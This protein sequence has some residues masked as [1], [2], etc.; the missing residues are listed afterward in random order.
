MA[1]LLRPILLLLF[2]GFLAPAWARV[3]LAVGQAAIA[4]AHPLATE[5]G[6]EILA[7]GGNAFDAAVAVSAA[8]AVVEPYASGVGGGGFWLLHRDSDGFETM[9]DGRETAPGAAF[10]DMYLDKSG[11]PLA[12]ASLTGP[13]AAAVPGMPAGLVRLARYGRLP[14]KTTMAPA[15]RLAE[16]GFTVDE[17][18]LRA[19][20]ETA[21]RLERFPQAA[22]IFLVAGRPPERGFVLRQPALA[23]TLRSIATHGHDGFYRGAVARVLVNSVRAAGGIWTLH[24]LAA[25]RALEREPVRFFYGGIRMT[26]AS[27]PSSGGVTLAQALQILEL[28]DLGALSAPENAHLVVEALRRAF[29]DRARYLGDP[30]FAQ[31]P[32]ARLVSKAYARERA[33]SIDP[34]RATPSASLEGGPVAARG[35][36]TTHF[37]IVDREGNRVAATL[38]IN[39]TFG[40][41]FV[42]GASGVLLNNEMD[43]FSIAPGVPNAYG[44][45]GS[46]ANA[47]APGKRPL[48]SMSP[49]FVEDGRGILAIGTPGGS[50][51]ISM[52]LL[53]ILEYAG[54]PAP[55]IERLFGAPRF[56]HQYLPDRV[57]YEPD[58]FSAAWVEGLR[59]RGHE[60]Q[61]G[62][63]RWGNMQG[64]FVD[65]R[66]GRVSAYNDPRGKAGALF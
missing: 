1:I 42:A 16:R 8:L 64:V 6:D 13:R 9:I 46:E 34:A 66:S 39:T 10:R 25:Y 62:G 43:D 2:L 4:S 57:E 24:D 15:I 12:E 22:A 65:K 51:I 54:S 30:E 61:E 55:D 53:A 21:G 32:L 44:L 35:E 40:A 5:A 38:S 27:L 48:S 50:R 18:Y 49:T 29:Q 63:R 19:A 37:S 58:G 28:F 59:A 60:L 31:P 36:S 47:I 11:K 52:V 20:R 45:V 7:R 3:P 56:H 14:L 41:G 17:R 23:A 33:A 26:T